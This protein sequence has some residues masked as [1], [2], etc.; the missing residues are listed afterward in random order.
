MISGGVCVTPRRRSDDVHLSRAP[1]GKESAIVGFYDELRLVLP[2]AGRIH[3][4]DQMV[5]SA[6]DSTRN[7]LH[8]LL[9]Y[10]LRN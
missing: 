1:D 3:L 6:I 10:E 5:F 7:F 2:V 8:P 9:Q 4:R